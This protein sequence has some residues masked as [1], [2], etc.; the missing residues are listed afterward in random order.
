[1]HEFKSMQKMH[2][3]ANTQRCQSPGDEL[4]KKV[5]LIYQKARVSSHES[6][7]NAEGLCICFRRSNQKVKSDNIL[8]DGHQAV[9]KSQEHKMKCEPASEHCSQL[10]TLWHVLINM[11]LL[12][13]G[14][15]PLF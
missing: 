6:V 5:R 15:D 7:S 10:P 4:E 11:Q 13:I 9:A 2:T 14:N 8:G 3:A 12:L 1:M